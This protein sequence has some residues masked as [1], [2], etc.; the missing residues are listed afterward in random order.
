MSAIFCHRVHLSKFLLS[1]YLGF[2][3]FSTDFSI[4]NSN[5]KHPTVAALIDWWIIRTTRSNYWEL[6]IDK[7]LRNCGQTCITWV[8]VSIVDHPRLFEEHISVCLRVLTADT[9]VV[10][11]LGWGWG[12]REGSQETKKTDSLS[13][14]SWICGSLI[15]SHKY[16]RNCRS[17]YKRVLQLFGRHQHSRTH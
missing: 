16:E 4:C 13:D 12:G 15:G 11:G 5:L 14:P 8:P 17:G 3:K 9:W 6:E 1:Q 2:V 7:F 10:S